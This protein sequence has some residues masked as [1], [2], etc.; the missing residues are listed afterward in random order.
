MLTWWLSLLMSF[1]QT[2]WKFRAS[3]CH[4]PTFSILYLL[5]DKDGTFLKWKLVVWN[6]SGLLYCSVY[7]PQNHVGVLV[8][9]NWCLGSSSMTWI[10]K[11]STAW[12]LGSSLKPWPQ[13]R[14]CQG[15]LGSAQ[16]SEIQLSWL[17]QPLGR[18][19][20]LSLAPCHC[21]GARLVPNVA[22]NFLGGVLTSCLAAHLCWEPCM[23]Y[24]PW[25][26]LDLAFGFMC[27]TGWI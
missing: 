20:T 1:V 11:D 5:T 26:V 27:S 4:K 17:G 2:S 13:T 18:P 10:W 3:F 14:P 23:W 8:L 6:A 16:W 7:S 15:N 9:W 19:Q 21:S 22:L 12:C 24:H 25:F